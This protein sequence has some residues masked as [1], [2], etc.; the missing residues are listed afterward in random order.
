LISL[1]L[2]FILVQQALLKQLMV[3]SLPD[4]KIDTVWTIEIV[5]KDD[6]S[7]MHCKAAPVSLLLSKLFFAKMRNPSSL[8]AQK[9]LGLS[10]QK[11]NG[12]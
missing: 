10:N 8:H 9:N 2:I 12:K 11:E 5:P 4:S 6:Y 7:L 1:G 3:Q